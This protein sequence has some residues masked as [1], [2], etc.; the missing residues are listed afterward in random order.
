M[1]ESRVRTLLL[2]AS[3][4]PRWE[5][6]VVDTLAGALRLSA[7]LRKA[8]GVLPPGVRGNRWV[9]SLLGVG[10][11]NLS[12]VQD[13]QDAFMENGQLDVEACNVNDRLAY[14]RALR[15]LKEYPLIVVLHSAAGDSM[16]PLRSAGKRWIDRRGKMLVFFG[17]EYNL[18]SEKIAFAQDGAVDYIASQLP[19]K[20]ARWLYSDCSAEVLAAPA[21]LNPAFYRPHKGRRPIDIGFRGDAYYLSLGDVE[22]TEFIREV[23]DETL[24]WGLIQDIAFKRCAREQ[25]R[26]F[27]C[28]CKGIV[29]AESGT[30]YLEK[31]DRTQ[32]AVTRFLQENPEAGF[33]EI[34]DRFFRDYPNPVSGKAV[35][36]RHFEP[37]GT[38]TCQILLEGEYNGVLEA[39]RHYIY[40]KK[41]FSGLD[42]S[43]RKF[44][45]PEFRKRIAE[46]ALAHA[47]SAHTYRHRVEALLK[48]VLKDV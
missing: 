15:R 18:M 11:C 14:G 22:R 17:N 21:A 7:G 25:W 12:Y 44:K 8:A 9:R 46:Q 29:G 45:A 47:L 41:D 10:Y 26:E 42:D 38:G 2:Y 36:S 3:G 34:H 6:T 28:S 39:D 30:Y 31:D 48:I 24:R 33:S 23:R 16:A 19:L 27:L 40:V 5:R 37:I 20:A 43:V 35:S 32:K 4:A 13:W 1:K